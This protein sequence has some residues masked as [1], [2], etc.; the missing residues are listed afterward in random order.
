[1]FLA[2]LWPL[3]FSFEP[4]LYEASPDFK[5]AAVCTRSFQENLFAATSL[6]G[7]FGQWQKCQ[8]KWVIFEYNLWQAHH[9]N[10]LKPV[11]WLVV[12]QAPPQLIA[13]AIRWGQAPWFGRLTMT[14]LP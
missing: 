9:D 14:N 5:Q 6:L 3:Q 13:I 2:L 8:M 4:N 11:L 12:R 7:T 1:L 10:A